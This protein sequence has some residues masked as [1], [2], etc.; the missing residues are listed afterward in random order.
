MQVAIFV[1]LAAAVS[2]LLARS[3][4]RLRIPRLTVANHRGRRVPV[5]LG[6]A[7]A[8][9]TTGVLL[10][11]LA[12]AAASGRWTEAA[13]VTAVIAGATAVVAV[14]GFLDDLSTGSARGWRGHFGAAGAGRATSGLG[15]VVGITLAAGVVAWALEPPQGPLGWGAFVAGTVVIAGMANVVNGLDVTPGRAGK[16]FLLLGV[17]LAFAAPEA[18]PWA[19][20]IVVLGAEIGVLWFDLRE[21]GILGDA[22][23]NLLGFVL[24]AAIVPALTPAGCI[25]AAVVV[26]LLN[27]VAETVTFSRII[28]SVAPLRWFDLLGRAPSGPTFSSN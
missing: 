22:G 11:A 4:T 9:A 27:I 26:V 1:V 13:R 12:T 25:A 6:I 15:K 10:G 19:V 24:G 2:A 28:G 14:I 8:G 21:R 16:W 7:V 5:V 18:P 23:A 3:L 20:L 17:P